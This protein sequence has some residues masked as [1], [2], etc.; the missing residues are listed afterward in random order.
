MKGN[1]E[2]SQGSLDLHLNNSILGGDVNLNDGGLTA[3]DVWLDNSRVVGNLYG[4]GDAS[5]LHLVNM[6]TF[7]GTTFSNFGKLA[8][9]GDLVLT[10]GFTDTNVGNALT[11][12]GTT[13][14]APWR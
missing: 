11:V 2:A 12:S 3:S 8:V 7:D 14:T 4:S 5:T 6:P 9:A 13:V 1:I 10:D